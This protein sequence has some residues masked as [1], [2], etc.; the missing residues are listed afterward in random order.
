MAFL[1][2]LITLDVMIRIDKQPFSSVICRK[3]V[4]MSLETD[5]ILAVCSGLSPDLPFGTEMIFDVNG[6][7]AFSIY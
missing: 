4:T 1:F 3:L 5:D 2:Y 7:K 6:L